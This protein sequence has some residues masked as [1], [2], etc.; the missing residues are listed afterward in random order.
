MKYM[1]QVVEGLIPRIEQ[2][3]NRLDTFYTC[4]LGSSKNSEGE[5]YS[6]L[7]KQFMVKMIDVVTEYL[8]EGISEGKKFSRDDVFNVVRVSLFMEFKKYASSLDAEKWFDAVYDMSLDRFVGDRPVSHFSIMDGLA[9]DVREGTWKFDD[10]FEELFGSPID[11]YGNKYGEVYSYELIELMESISTTLKD[12]LR[13]GYVVDREAYYNVTK[14]QMFTTWG[15]V[16]TDRAMDL[17]Y[18]VVF[19]GLID[20]LH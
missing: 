16:P 5:S 8:N 2:G 20:D 19:E 17:W 9:L 12:L 15:G 14:Y 3:T 1:L 10:F 7:H 4:F 13:S 6:E 11:E 18:D